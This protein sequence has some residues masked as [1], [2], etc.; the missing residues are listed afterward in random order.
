MVINF[1]EWAARRIWHPLHVR[2][3]VVK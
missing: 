2:K 1:P 3:G